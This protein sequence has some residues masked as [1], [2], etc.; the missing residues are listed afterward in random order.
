ML[1]I[2]IMVVISVITFHSSYCLFYYYHVSYSPSRCM[3]LQHLASYDMIGSIFVYLSLISVL[4]ISFFRSYVSSVISF[5]IL[6]LLLA[7][8]LRMSSTNYR[9]V[10]LIS[11]S[12]TKNTTLVDALVLLFLLPLLPLYSH[13]LNPYC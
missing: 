2:K 8:L 4:R 11:F 5:F 9:C 6:V 7:S 1:V 13:S 3:S 10:I 12:K